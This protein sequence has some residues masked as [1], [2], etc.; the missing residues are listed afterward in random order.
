MKGGPVGNAAEPE[1]GP[2]NAADRRDARSLVTDGAT[3][4]DDG[5]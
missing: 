4:G 1:E 2:R 5:P 3:R